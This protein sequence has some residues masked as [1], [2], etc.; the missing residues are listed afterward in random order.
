MR[1]LIFDHLITYKVKQIKEKWQEGIFLMEDFPLNHEVYQNGPV[2][3]SF[4]AEQ[5]GS[6]VGTFTYY[7]PINEAVGLKEGTDFDVLERLYVE[8]SLVLRQAD[9][10]VDFN[11]AYQ[12]VK[13]YAFEHDIAIEETFFCVLLEVYGEL[14][15]DL[16]IPVKEQSGE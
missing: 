2:F 5:Q 9:E 8:K 15:I 6:D 11:V 1:P 4:E 10:E 7:L 12:K 13:D 16:Y 3:F 14:I